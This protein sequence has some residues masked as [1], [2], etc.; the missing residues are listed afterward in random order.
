MRPGAIA[1]RGLVHARPAVV[2]PPLPVY[3]AE[4]RQDPEPQQVRDD[5]VVQR[6]RAVESRGRVLGRRRVD[7]EEVRRRPPPSLAVG[8]GRQHVVEPEV[9]EPLVIFPAPDEGRDPFGQ[10]GEARG[11]GRK[12]LAQRQVVPLRIRASTGFGGEEVGAYLPREPFRIVAVRAA[13]R[14]VDRVV[15]A[16]PAASSSSVQPERP[17][18]DVQERAAVDER[19]PVRRQEAVGADVALPPG[20]EDGR[21]RVALRDVPVGRVQGRRPP[22]EE[23][24]GVGPVDDPDAAGAVGR[25]VLDDPQAGRRGGRRQVRRG[26]QEVLEPE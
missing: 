17:V 4:V 1:R 8:D 23:A 6:L 13:V 26:A 20:V 2:L 24:R 21:P 22:L 19:P 15:E 14:D 18:G 10:R 25:G 9:L 3:D 12:V 11:D 5:L 16:S 7:L